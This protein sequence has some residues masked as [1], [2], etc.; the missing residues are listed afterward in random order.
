VRRAARVDANHG[1]VR[2][3]IRFVGRPCKDTS[4]YPEFCDLVALHLAGHPVL[5]E[6]KDGDKPPSA[7]KLTPAQVSFHMEFPV[8][9]VKNE[10]EGLIAIGY[11]ADA[12]AQNVATWD[13]QY[14]QRELRRRAR[15]KGKR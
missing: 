12:A 2:D 3:R 1:L 10:V 9:V 15:Q 14:V 5:M 7:R 13:A 8:V 4:A 11:P 6:V